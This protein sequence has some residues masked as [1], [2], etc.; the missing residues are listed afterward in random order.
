MRTTYVKKD[1]DRQPDNSTEAALRELE[2]IAA[3]WV[4][5]QRGRL[6]VAD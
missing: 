5:R 1:V 3:E 4:S 2:L 6:N